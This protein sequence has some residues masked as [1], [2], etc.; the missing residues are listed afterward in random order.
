VINSSVA[1]I[2]MTEETGP[3]RDLS[4]SRGINSKRIQLSAMVRSSIPNVITLLALF[5]GLTSIRFSGEGHSGWAA[6]AIAA[7][8]F[9]DLADGFAARRLAAASVIGAE[10]DSLADLVNF[11]V[12]PAM[13]VYRQDLSRLGFTGWAIAASYVLAAALRLAR[14]NAEAKVPSSPLQIRFFRGLPSTGAALAMVAAWYAV[15]ATLTPPIT[16]AALAAVTIAIAALMLSTIRVPAFSAGG[17]KR[18]EEK[19]R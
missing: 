6:G 11:G 10:L 3:Q 7:A 9:F 17:T 8:A 14:F 2:V 16:T 4:I 19:R 13:L 12:A 15:H 5:C 18:Q 1:V